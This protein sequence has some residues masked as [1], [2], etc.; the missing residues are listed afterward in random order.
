LG[1]EKELSEKDVKELI[2]VCKKENALFLQ[3]ENIDYL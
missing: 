2:K 3:V 1:L